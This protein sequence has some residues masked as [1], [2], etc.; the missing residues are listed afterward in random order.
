MNI[1][2]SKIN[3][4]EN[5]NLN[6]DDSGAPKAAMIGG[7]SRLYF[8]SQSVKRPVRLAMHT[9]NAGSY[10][11]IRT[12]CLDVVVSEEL[13]AAGCPADKVEELSTLVSEAFVGGAKKP[14]APKR[15]KKA[16]EPEEE[17]EESGSTIGYFAPSEVKGIVEF[18]KGA[19]WDPSSAKDK[20][21]MAKEMA[22]VRKVAGCMDA[23]DIAIFGRMFASAPDLNV[24]AASC[25][26]FA[27]STHEATSE[28]DFFT[29]VDDLE[30]GTG[31]AHMGTKEFGSA[32]MASTVVLDVD[33][34]RDN[35]PGVSD[36]VVQSTVKDFILANLR[37]GLP[38]GN[39]TSMLPNTLPQYAVVTVCEGVA[40]AAS[41]ETP[42]KAGDLGGYLQGS[43]EALKKEVSRINS[44]QKV[45]ASEVLADPEGFKEDVL[46]KVVSHV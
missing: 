10:G 27:V 30:K 9:A 38:K 6:R 29:A 42:V 13:I 36:A 2:I 5:A 45:L 43:I 46:N 21:A 19:G 12:K 24:D 16:E 44:F 3:A 25:Y 39:M 33:Q 34:L 40:C 18:L 23:V 1:I 7:S 11:G 4:I 22:Q 20:K 41:F 8:S 37:H 14:A 17:M 35:L 32:V 28:V 15:G 31:S 26:S